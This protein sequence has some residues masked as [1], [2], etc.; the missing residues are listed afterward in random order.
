MIDQFSFLSYSE[1]RQEVLASQ[2][3][4]HN[5]CSK[6]YVEKKCLAVEALIWL[7]DAHGLIVHSADE[8]LAILVSVS[9]VDV[10]TELSLGKCLAGSEHVLEGALSL[11]LDFFVE[12]KVRELLKNNLIRDRILNQNRQLRF[13]CS[14]R[15]LAG[16]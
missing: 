2:T 16:I 1:Y 15:N 14:R 6:K 3:Q 10:Q 9:H 12:L 8:S 13:E 11:W 5:N 4:K 7:Y